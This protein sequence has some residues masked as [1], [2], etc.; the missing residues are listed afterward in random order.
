MNIHQFS[1]VCTAIA[2]S[3][4]LSACATQHEGIHSKMQS[5]G[6]GSEKFSS[7]QECCHDS[8]GV[9]A[10]SDPNDYYVASRQSVLNEIDKTA[11]QVKKKKITE[12]K[13]YD[14]LQSVM[15]I[16]I[17]E[18]REQSQRAAAIVGVM[19]VGV[20][21]VSCIDSGSCGGGGHSSSYYDGNCPCPY[22][23]DA[24]GNLCG[25]RSAYSRTGGAS[26]IC[27]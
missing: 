1:R 2:A 3:I 24:S 14:N 26:P 20:A 17:I 9:S 10:S 21:A 11:L 4:F 15:Q 8:L 23:L 22:S 18:E 12:K 16:K 5:C 6:M 19:L 25:A 27:Y 7:F 13:G